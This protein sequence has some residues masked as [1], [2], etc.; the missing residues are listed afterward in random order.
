MAIN[1]Y[2]KT[3]VIQNFATFKNQTIQ[4][5][6]GLNTIVGETGSGKSLVLDALQLILG[7]RADKKI[8]R[9]D[10]DHSLIEAT[11]FCDDPEIHSFIVQEGY[12]ADGKELVIKRVINSN[13]TTKT[14]FNHLVSS[15]NF[16]TKFAKSYI[17]LVGQFE[18]QK[19]LS[20]QYQLQLLDHYAKLSTEVA[21]Y[22]KNFQ[23]WK[24]LEKQIND[25]TQSKNIREQRLDYLN[26]QIHE[27]ESLNPSS[28]DEQQLFMKKSL[29]LNL[30]KNQKL[31]FQVKQIFEGLEGGSGLFQHLKSLTTLSL[32]NSDIFN[33]H[34]TEIGEIEDKLYV[35]F[36]D[37]VNRLEIEVDPTEIDNV[38]ERL[39]LYTKLKRKFGGTI[40]SLLSAYEEFKIE[41]EKLESLDINLEE[42]IKA[43]NISE[44]SLFKRAHTL[45]AKRKE[46]AKK[47]SS[48]L[49]KKVQTLKMNGA[50]IKLNSE[51][52]ETLNEFGKTHVGFFAETNPGEGFFKIK[53]I[54]SGGELSRILLAM[55]QIL[56]SYDSI[57]IFMFDEI[58]T[59]IGGET[60][61][62]IGKALHD[63]STTGQV[64]AITH[65]PQ[66]AQFADSLIL[67]Q[68][69]IHQTN[70]N[71]RT[72]SRV[73]E[74]V[75]KMVMKEVKQMGQLTQF[76]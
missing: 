47:L 49:T 56:S 60:A 1:F 67:V 39:D 34:A 33:Q 32:K 24:D 26:Y 76:Q 15:L 52:S 19:L 59:G 2:L 61:V 53:D 29:L 6:P 57:S 38:L 21:E 40:E 37:I 54:A 27:I 45:H 66:I 46:S 41:K 23:T 9:K 7:A 17:D 14:Y 70:Q 72:E 16:L 63:V 75:G 3:L 5:R 42:L 55:R 69:D 51:E 43:K 12:P 50:T 73:K 44:V 4:F 28:Q 11:F 58:D 48:E 35:V 10:A 20:G 74:I 68:K 36:S 64:I 8:V 13:G 18:N 22:Q 31:L 30:E 71:A 62:C 25:L 65:L